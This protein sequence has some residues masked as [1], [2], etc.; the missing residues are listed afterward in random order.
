MVVAMAAAAVHTMAVDR[1]AVAL[2]NSNSYNHSY[3]GGR[4][5]RR[6]FAR[7]LMGAE[8]VEYAG[9]ETS[10]QWRCLIN[11]GQ[12]ASFLVV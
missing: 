6:V 8:L 10:L 7:S 4:N 1:M 9:L 3:R 11:E 2:T 5:A 12:V